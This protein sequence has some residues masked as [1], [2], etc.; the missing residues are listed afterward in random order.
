MFLRPHVLGGLLGERGFSFRSR[1]ERD[2]CVN[3][4][5]LIRGAWKRPTYEFTKN[6]MTIPFEQAQRGAGL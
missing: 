6:M 3:N 5:L 4:P 1:I 2:D